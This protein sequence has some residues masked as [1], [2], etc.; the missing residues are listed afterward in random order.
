[1]LPFVKAGFHSMARLE[2]EGRENVPAKGPLIVV[3][4]HLNTID[5]P[6]LGVIFPRQIVFVAKDELFGFPSVM[7]MKA[8]GAFSAR[9]FG[10]S[11]MAIRQAL[12]VLRKD[13]V[14]G[15]FPEGRRSLDHQLSRGE[16]GAAYIALRSGAPVV[17]IGISGSEQFESRM[18]LLK[19][20]RIRVVIGQPFSV[21]STRKKPSRE[22]VIETTELIMQHIAHILP[23]SY[24]G[25][26]DG[27]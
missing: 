26:Y 8:L 27:E 16:D 17:P 15:I 9:K 3:A 4:N 24:R 10:K 1:M 14:L 25:V 12:Q 11:G 19:R 18:S 2:I 21:K 7:V 13:Q 23:P 20:C 6:L 5:P 22:Q